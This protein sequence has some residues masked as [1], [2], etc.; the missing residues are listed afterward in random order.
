MDKVISSTV[1]EYGDQMLQSLHQLQQRG[2]NC[3]VTLQAC[4]GSANIHNIILAAGSYSFFEHQQRCNIIDCRKYS[5]LVVEA[6]IVLLYTGKISI[7]ERYL[8]DLMTL[9]EDLNLG[10]ACISLRQHLETHFERREP[11]LIKA[12]ESGIPNLA[13]TCKF[14]TDNNLS[15]HSPASENSGLYQELVSKSFQIAEN[16]H[17]TQ[18]Q[19]VNEGNYLYLR[20][21]DEIETRND[22]KLHSEGSTF[23]NQ[24]PVVNN[25]VK[26]TAEHNLL[27]QIQ[28]VITEYM[29]VSQEKLT[30]VSHCQNLIED[31]VK[32]LSHIGNQINKEYDSSKRDKSIENSLKGSLMTTDF[33]EV[34]TVTTRTKDK[35]INNTYKDIG[36]SNLRSSK[37]NVTAKKR[38]LEEPSTEMQET[39][40][41]NE[42]NVHSIK[43]EE[44]LS[45]L[46]DKS[47]NTGSNYSIDI[48]KSPRN[49]I[50][51]IQEKEE[52]LLLEKRFKKNKNNKI[53]I[54]RG[55][56]LSKIKR[57]N[58]DTE[59]QD[60]GKKSETVKEYDNTNNINS[61]K[62]EF[63]CVKCN[64]IFPSYSERRKHMTE[65]HRPYPCELCSWVGCQPHLFAA[66]MYGQHKVVIFP[67]KYPLVE[68]DAEGCFHKCLNISLYNHKRCHKYKT[69][70][71]VC[72]VCG[73]KFTSEGGLR[74]H[75]SYHA[76]ENLKHRCKECGKVFGWDHEL[77]K[78]MNAEH[79]NYIL[80]H[81]CPFKTKY[82]T[83][84][85]IH[86]HNK[87][88]EPVPSNVKIC[89]CDSCDFYCFY[90]S[91]LKIH[92]EENH[93]DNSNYSCAMCSKSFKSRKSWRCHQNNA[94][95]ANIY[96][97]DLCNYTTN[98]EKNLMI[99]KN[100]RHSEVRPYG[101]HLC[102]YSC[103]FKGNL[104]KHMKNKHKVEI[105]S[106]YKLYEKMIKTGKGYDEYMNSRRSSMEKM[107]TEIKT[108]PINENR[109]KTYVCI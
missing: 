9:C 64:K 33:D 39:S 47:E 91:Y 78:H 107:S 96:N 86:L 28:N 6:A 74:S 23:R 93:S 1:P 89:K 81:K 102:E 26:S 76:E 29:S 31:V 25:K 79:R 7:E 32:M 27:N 73:M 65:I 58:V 67:K 97:C 108:Q 30:T 51:S 85:K 60:L 71:L 5:I 11:V 88:G 98:H 41:N 94:H 87:H 77:S 2:V 46:P 42:Q 44:E 12:C 3:D 36:Y 103:K 54:L 80:C 15:E 17:A 18:L 19:A 101:C 69:D 75:T 55:D 48:R 99:H 43:L 92:K 4:N 100:C 34:V 8:I 82:Q 70:K 22:T 105:V 63:K 38:K 68:C 95:S 45:F 106:S 24:K 61:T 52:K 20:I 37:D 57:K 109:D 40:K 66:H 56:N 13:A 16:V 50:A 14:S 90:P 83:T 49:K 84:L 59:K 104:N 72:H 62:K 21:T 53:Q 35:V 10:S